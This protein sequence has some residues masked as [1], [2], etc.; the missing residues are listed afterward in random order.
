MIIVSVSFFAE[1]GKRDKIVEISQKAIG[2]T[3]KEKGEIS[4]TLFKNSDD[5]TTLMYG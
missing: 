1:T 5:D 2:L 4:Y 3:R